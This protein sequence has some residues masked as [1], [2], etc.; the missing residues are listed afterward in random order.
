MCTDII[1]CLIGMCVEGG[2]V[3]NS[4]TVVRYVIE[5]IYMSSLCVRGVVVVVLKEKIFQ[6][7]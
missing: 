5:K 7:D 1:E 3:R 6:L 2:S 4:S